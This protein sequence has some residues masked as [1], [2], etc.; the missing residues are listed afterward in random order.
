MQVYL[1]YRKSS[2][3]PL[4]KFNDSRSLTH[5][6]FVEVVKR[7]LKVARVNSFKK[8]SSYNAASQ[9]LSGSTI[10]MLGRWR[11]KLLPLIH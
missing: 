8:W 1:S 10:I 4:F 7:A 3:V 2:L 5:S 9:G 11:K 6:K